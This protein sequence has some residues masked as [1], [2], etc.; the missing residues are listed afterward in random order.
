VNC[1][2]CTG[3]PTAFCR[4]KCRTFLGQSILPTSWQPHPE[5]SISQSWTPR[6]WG[7]KESIC[8]MHPVSSFPKKLTNALPRW[9]KFSLEQLA[10]DADV[11]SHMDIR[12]GARPSRFCRR[13][14]V[15]RKCK[16]IAGSGAGLGK[17]GTSSRRPPEKHC[18]IQDA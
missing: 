1:F 10:R 17:R 16:G 2:A 18:S 13:E 15:A 8:T 4:L 9:S 6:S 7:L 5:G 3:R 14:W 11:R 12:G